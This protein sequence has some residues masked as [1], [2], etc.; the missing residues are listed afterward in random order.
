[1]IEDQKADFGTLGFE[2][3]IE[4]SGKYWDFNVGDMPKRQ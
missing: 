4:E 3:Q 1:M 2:G